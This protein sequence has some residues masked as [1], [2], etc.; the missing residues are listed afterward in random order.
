[1]LSDEKFYDK[2]ANFCLVKNVDGFY[3]TLEEYRKLTEGNQTDKDGQLCYLYSNDKTAQ[4]SYI[5]AAKAK[6]YDVL[7]MDGQLDTPFMNQQEQKQEK[8]HFSRIDADTITKLIK[9]ADDKKVEFSEAE[10]RENDKLFSSQIPECK[11][12]EGK[13]VEWTVEFQA[14][15]ETDK[16]VMI[17]QN[18]W[19]RRMKEMSKM[20]P[21]MNY[22]GMMPDSYNL[23]VN[24]EHPVVKKILTQAHAAVDA[25][26]LAVVNEISDKEGQI[27]PL[28]DEKYKAKAGEFAQ[29]KQDL[30][31]ALQDDVK[32]LKEKE[33]AEMQKYGATDNALRQLIDLALLEGG[34]L[35]GEALAAFIRRSQQLL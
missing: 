7:E 30:L 15:D 4:Y 6:G 32:A 11:N 19:M 12:A 17:A 20:Q 2:A 14:M 33:S 35:K 25:D 31:K 13:P 16:P 8:C 9:K 26:L 3:Y 18:E 21:G 24:T 1:M 28:E 22:Y 5:E 23:I 29:D 10:R 34:M 27:K